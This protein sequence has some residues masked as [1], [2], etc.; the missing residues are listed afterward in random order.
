ME[1]IKF[2]HCHKLKNVLKYELIKF[3]LI[4]PSERT[5]ISQRNKNYFQ[6]YLEF[7]NLHT[8]FENLS[9]NF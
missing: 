8:Q 2:N 3:I 4:T 5:L 1:E 7:T 9:I 6:Y